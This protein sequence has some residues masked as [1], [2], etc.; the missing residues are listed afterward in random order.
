MRAEGSLRDAHPAESSAAAVAGVMQWKVDVKSGAV[1]ASYSDGPYFFTHAGVRP[2]LLERLPTSSIGE[3]V[4]YLNDRLRDAV[5]ECHE[6]PV[7][8]RYLERACRF[9][10][11]IFTAGIDRGG[12]GVGGTF[13]TD[14]RIL[15]GAAAEALPDAVQIVGDHSH[16]LE[17]DSRRGAG[18]GANEARADP[19]SVRPASRRHRRGA[20]GTAFQEARVEPRDMLWRSWLDLR[21]PPARGRLVR[22]A[23]ARRG[24][25]TR[26]G[27]RLVMRAIRQERFATILLFPTQAPPPLPRGREVQRHQAVGEGR[28]DARA[29]DC[30]RYRRSLRIN[31]EAARPARVD[32]DAVRALVAS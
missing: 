26:G 11:D 13:W 31:A 14:W 8:G 20:V 21:A 4:S 23:E 10:D 24:P 3:L 5:V 32:A 9:K 22:V 25:W 19:V 6:N 28:L 30:H 18:R 2:A 29:V 15:D 17:A 16:W 1:R 12:R 7:R 27:R